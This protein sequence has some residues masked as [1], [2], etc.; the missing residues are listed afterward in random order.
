VNALNYRAC[1]CRVRAAFWPARR[2]PSLPLVRTA[3]IA[4]LCKD[5]RPRLLAAL[6]VCRESADLEAFDLLSLFKAFSVARERLGDTLRLP[7]RPFAR[8]R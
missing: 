5:E 2:N 4:A 8:S 7:E 1:R 6:R 3:F